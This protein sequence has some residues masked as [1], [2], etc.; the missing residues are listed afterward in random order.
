MT[1]TH[2]DESIST[3]SRVPSLTTI[4]ILYLV[5]GP[6][7]ILTVPLLIP[8]S[9]THDFFAGA[10]VAMGRS[11]VFVGIIVGVF[12]GAC[13]RLGVGVLV[14]LKTTSGEHETSSINTTDRSRLLLTRHLSYAVVL[15][16]EPKLVFI[17][18]VRPDHRSGLCPP[19]GDFPETGDQPD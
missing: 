11:G 1:C 3:V 6:A 4:T 12:A 7:R 14:D 8:V 19:I 9:T 15:R 5:P 17:Q 18:I 2:S 16:Y 13:V 10:T